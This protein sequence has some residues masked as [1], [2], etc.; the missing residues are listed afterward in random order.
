M[1]LVTGTD[2]R[3]QLGGR[4]TTSLDTQAETPAVAQVRGRGAVLALE[5][6][7]P[8]TAALT[9]PARTAQVTHACHRTGVV[10]TCGSN[11]N[12]IRLLPP[13]VVPPDLLAEGLDVLTRAVLH[14]G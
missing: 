9:D 3:G 14:S 13:L 12:V 2:R 10:L 1:L 5:F 6:I 4:L 8:A 7:D 11:A